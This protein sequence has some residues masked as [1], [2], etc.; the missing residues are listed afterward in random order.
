[1]V[2]CASVT[3]DPRVDHREARPAR[4]REQASSQVVGKA[5][6]GVDP[7]QVLA[8]RQADALVAVDERVAEEDGGSD[9]A[10]DERVDRV[11]EA[12]RRRRGAE[13]AR[14]RVGRVI[15]ARGGRRV[16]PLAPDE[17]AGGRPA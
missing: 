17:V 7:G 8:A 10:R 12:D 2:C 4:L 15:A 5:V 9:A 16:G 1:M 6:V 13:R 3:A 11:E 14:R